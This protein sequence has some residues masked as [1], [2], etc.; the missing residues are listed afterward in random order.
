[1][2]VVVG[3]YRVYSG[4]QARLTV[5]ANSR[6]GNN[7]TTGHSEL[8]KVCREGKEEREEEEERESKGKTTSEE[9]EG[10]QRPFYGKSK[11]GCA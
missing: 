8:E 7:S 3:E 9:A 1:M 4:E 11:R 10:V 2:A 6:A 5:A